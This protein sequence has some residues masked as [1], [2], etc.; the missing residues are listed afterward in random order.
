MR[1]SEAGNLYENG[2][3]LTPSMGLKFLVDDA[4]S[5]NI[6]VQQGFTPSGSWNFFD[7][8]LTN[9]L[10]QGFDTTTVDGYIMD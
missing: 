7:A 4:Q 3:G 9:R 6:L 5:E 10:P 8:D 1:I 2:K